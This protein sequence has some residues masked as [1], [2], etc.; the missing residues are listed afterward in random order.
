MAPALIITNSTI[1]CVRIEPRQ[2]ELVRQAWP[3]LDPAEYC[4]A[5]Y[6]FEK[7][8]SLHDPQIH[9]SNSMSEAYPMILPHRYLAF[10]LW[11]LSYAVT[12]SWGRAWIFITL[13]ATVLIRNL[14]LCAVDE[15]A[16]K[17]FVSE[18][19]DLVK[20]PIPDVLLDLKPCTL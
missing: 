14:A 16:V 9:M 5:I 17:S 10:S 8:D 15:A 1:Q 19:R 6:I 12:S 2:F 3:S 20:S 13:K 7:I 11:G 4:D 18:L